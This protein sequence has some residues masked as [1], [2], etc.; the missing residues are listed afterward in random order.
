MLTVLFISTIIVGLCYL[1]GERKI[2]RL[3]SKNRKL[4]ADLFAAQLEI[5]SAEL[6]GFIR[7]GEKH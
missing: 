5:N 3:E 6:K 2:D 7:K 4:K 1:Q